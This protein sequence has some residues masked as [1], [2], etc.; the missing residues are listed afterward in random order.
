MPLDQLIVFMLQFYIPGMWS[1]VFRVFGFGYSSK[2]RVALGALVYTAY[3]FLLPWFLMSSMGYSA[4]ILIA[5]MIMTIGSMSVL[6][7]TTDTISKTIFLQLAQGGVITCLS[8][9][10]DLACTLLGLSSL[11]L[12][13]I[14]FIC[15]PILFFIGLRFWA[16]PLRFLIDNIHDSMGLLLLLPLL[17]LA[18]VTVIPVFP[19]NSFANHPVFCTAMV[20][21]VEMAFFL[22]IYVLYRNIRQISDLSKREMQSELLSQEIESYQTYVDSARRSRH[23]LRQHDALVLG[24]LTD[25]KVDQA[26]DYLKCQVDELGMLSL[27]RYCQNTVMNALL[28]VYEGRAEK[29]GIQFAAV[30]NLP[31]HLPLSDTDL[32][33]LTGN[34]LEN[35][36]HAAANVDGGFISVNASIDGDDMLIMVR[37]SV[38]GQ[39]I[40]QQGLPVSKRPGGGTGTRSIE[41]IVQRYGGMADFSQSGNEFRT[42]IIVPIGI[43]DQNT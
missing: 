29:S 42:R 4:Y 38:S 17:T 6:I 35:A 13:V 2:E 41:T 33:A 18:V 39:V 9:V 20:L 12:S 22:Y 28:R 43:A 32:G 23:D 3:M 24:M 37:N 10:A 16:H 5:S 36:V 40:F 21:L 8:I 30:V 15:S 27:T 11:T 34:A 31:E 14:L 25:G 7:F 1:I 19:T 26:T